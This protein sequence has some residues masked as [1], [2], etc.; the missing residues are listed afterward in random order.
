MM[1]TKKVSKSVRILDMIA[2]TGEEGMRFTD[3]QRALWRMSH[4]VP[5][6]RALR[7]YWCTNLCGGMYYHQGLLNFF[8]VKGEDGRWRRNEVDHKGHPWSVMSGFRKKYRNT[9]KD[10]RLRRQEMYQAR[11]RA[12]GV[13]YPK[14]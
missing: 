4:I 1:E 5:F 2:E 12:L 3:I 11:R 8:C 9:I 14:F 7:G 13:G 6:T 10:D